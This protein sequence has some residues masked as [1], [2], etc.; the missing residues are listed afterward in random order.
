MAIRIFLGALLVAAINGPVDAQHRNRATGP[1]TFYAAP[2]GSDIDND[3]LSA[4]KPCS[5][6]RAPSVGKADWDFGH[7]SCTIRLA[8]GTYAGKVIMAG[9]YVGTHLC[10]LLARSTAKTTALTGALRYRRHQLWPP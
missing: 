6:Q 8:D 3:C 5:P 1:V 10:D 4:A 9:Q 2:N 7:G